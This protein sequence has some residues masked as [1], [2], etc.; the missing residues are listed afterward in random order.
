MG[1]LGKYG[2]NAL[3]YWGS[4]LASAYAGA[5]TADMWTAIRTQQQDY[6]LDKP[7]AS[8]PDVS[9]LRGYANRIVASQQ[10]LA[11][12]S[13]TD[14]ITASM[15]AVAPYTASD[16]AGIATTPTYHVRY[17]NTVQ[18]ADGTVTQTWATS[19]FTGTDMPDTVGD[20]TDAVSLH[21]TEIAAQ[22][23]TSG[24]NTPTGTSLGV[25]N[26]EITLI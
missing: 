6:G 12:A 8:A 13:A 10:A 9:V 4:I 24:G 23:S 14:T 1:V 16:L 21:G 26:I 11:S 15:M 17:L 22:G 20:L 19:V 18:A 5:S 7:G 25:S 3:K 2:G